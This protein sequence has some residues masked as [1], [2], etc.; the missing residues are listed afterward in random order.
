MENSTKK[1]KI[2]NNAPGFLKEIL[3]YISP[4]I[5]DLVDVPA[6]AINMGKL[7]YQYFFSK[8]ISKAKDHIH[9]YLPEKI[10]F[11]EVCGSNITKREYGEQLLELYFTQVLL[12]GIVFLDLRSK[13]FSKNNEGVIWS[14]NGL[15]CEF[16]KKFITGLKNLYEGFYLNNGQQYELGLMEIGLINKNDSSETREDIM[17][18]FKDHFGGGDQGEVVFKIDKF[19][20]SF[21]LI[22]DRIFHQNKKLSEDFVY[23]GIYLV[24]L[25]LHLEEIGEPLNVRESFNRAFEKLNNRQ[26]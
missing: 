23:L 17:S 5:F 24:T 3:P 10:S 9:H 14:P 4:R 22:F 18:I 12:G 7:S 20:N 2:I 11:N 15:Y 1:S 26:K 19:M 25:Y 6:V 21:Q 13:V 16:D 8:G